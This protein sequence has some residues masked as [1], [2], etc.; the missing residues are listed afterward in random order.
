[1]NSCRTSAWRLSFLVLWLFSCS[2]SQLLIFSLWFLSFISS[3]KATKTWWCVKRLCAVNTELSARVL[4]WQREKTLCHFKKEEREK[5]EKQNQTMWSLLLLLIDRLCAHGH[6][7]RVPLLKSG[8]FLS[9]FLRD[10][11]LW[12]EEKRQRHRGRFLK[13]A[14]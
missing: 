9:G 13:N 8:L 10:Y 5:A 3:I 1:M 14:K 7:Q 2:L 6:Q 12:D 4:K 11:W